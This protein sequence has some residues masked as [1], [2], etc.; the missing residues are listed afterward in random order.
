MWNPFKRRGKQQPP[1][2]PAAPAA[3]RPAEVPA[4]KPRGLLKRVFGRK[5]KQ[6]PTPP[7]TPP[8]QPAAPAPAPAAPGG[9]P[10]AGD[11]APRRDYPSALPVSGTGTWKIS[12]S[13]WRGTA[14]GT[15]TGAAV[16]VF[17]DAM[18]AGDTETPTY[19]IATAYD[20]GSGFA[21]MLDLSGTSIDISYG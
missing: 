19:L 10:P 9:A 17:I 16:R 11:Q 13:L 4:P 7:P 5:P 20:D 3:A 2:Q 18:E 8:A 12:S 1:E 21:D 6:A 14:S 15:L